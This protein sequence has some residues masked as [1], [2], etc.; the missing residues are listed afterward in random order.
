MSL[1]FAQRY[2]AF[3]IAPNF[4]RGVAVNFVVVNPSSYVYL[5]PARPS[6][7]GT[8]FAAPAATNCKYDDYKY[9]LGGRSGYVARLTR[10]QVL[11]HQT[12]REVVAAHT[13]RTVMRVEAHI[14]SKYVDVWSGQV[15][16]AS[17]PGNFFETMVYHTDRARRVLPDSPL[18]LPERAPVEYRSG[19]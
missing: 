10:E 18:L 6:N 3:G 17:A 14:E 8:Q 15:T 12:A 16:P 4:A 2:A 13:A 7:N 19:Y 9:G 5:D 11:A 1:Q